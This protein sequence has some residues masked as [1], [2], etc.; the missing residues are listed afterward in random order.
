MTPEEIE[1]E[2]KQLDP[3]KACVENDL[4]SKIFIGSNDIVSKYLSN[5]NNTYKNG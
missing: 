2:I 3:K 1:K 5:I 4:P